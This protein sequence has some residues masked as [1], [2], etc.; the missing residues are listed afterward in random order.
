MND[1]PSYLIWID[2]EMTGLDPQND[3]IIEIATIITDSRLN[4]VAY[5][6]SLAIHQPEE[7]MKKMDDWNTKQHTQSGLVE[8]VRQST[9]TLLEAQKQTLAFLKQYV[10][11]KA[12]PM[13][14]NTVCQD[15]R[16]LARWM[17]AL[18]A[19]FHYRHLD[20]STV[21]ELAKLWAP[22]IFKGLT[23]QSKH[24]ALDDIKESIDELCYYRDR[25]FKLETI[26]SLP[27][28]TSRLD[29]P[30]L[31]HFIPIRQSTSNKGDHGHV[32]IIGAGKMQ[33]G[34]SVCLSGEAA[35]RAGAGLVS[36][37]VAPESIVRSSQ[38]P[39]ELMIMAYQQPI[40]AKSL[41]DKASV[42]ILGPGLSE[43]DWAEKWFDH[44]IAQ[45]LPLV[46][47]A[48][49]LNWLAKCP[50]KVPHAVLTPHP[51]E[52]ARLLATTVEAI[53]QDRVTAA[54]ALQAKYDGVVVLKGA[55]TII[56][57]KEQ[58]ISVLEEGIPSLAT[59][60][61][62]DVLAGIIG[63]LIAQGLELARAAEL[64][65]CVHAMAGKEQ[66]Q[67]GIRG[68]MASD[69]LPSIRAFLNPV[70]GNNG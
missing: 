19:H 29:Y 69:L 60:G 46:I 47:D 44:V 40:E 30:T 63:A 11:A 70:E 28:D 18:E 12:S 39:A 65:V 57:D 7:I 1:K 64:A 16:F 38:A 52:A 4:I 37:V 8:R 14:G 10:P 23:K 20:V 21:K 41:F 66:Q 50:Q 56:V 27:P 15:R 35:L 24:L 58:K 17:P 33:Y 42:F 54:R 59:A 32:V 45:S 61:T 34:G 3:Q 22:E 62:G 6:P 51:G 36:V 53:Q 31:K 68:M 2:L 48:D 5:G 49:G 43:S 13:C 9:I 67:K 25:F 55:G 26:A